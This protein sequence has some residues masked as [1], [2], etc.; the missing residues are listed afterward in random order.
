MPST[1]SSDAS[2]SY[3]SRTTSDETDI[4]VIHSSETGIK[5]DTTVKTIPRAIPS[6]ETYPYTLLQENNNFPVDLEKDG[7]I[8]YFWH[9]HKSGG[10]SMKQA[11]SCLNK[12]QT[13]RIHVPRICSDKEPKLRICN[14][15]NGSRIINADISSVIGIQ[16]AL[17]LELTT[18]GSI[19]GIDKSY[20][21]MGIQEE[22]FIINTSRVYEALRIFNSERKARLFILFRD[23]IER[24]IS[25]YYYMKISTWENT[26]D[27]EVAKMDL[28]TYVKSK[29]CYSNW[30]TRRLVNKMEGDLSNDD[31]ELAK[32]IL[33]RKALVLLL[34]DFQGSIE[35]VRNFFGWENE[36]LTDEQQIC[37]KSL[38]ENPINANGRKQIVEQGS[39][40]WNIIREKNLMDLQLMSFVTN[41]YK[42]QGALFFQTRN[43]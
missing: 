5:P 10:S 11:F 24:V 18:K 19:Y 40:E 42:E 30:V 26:Y 4:V 13:K 2:L 36:I 23:P 21:E 22:P 7:D 9:I 3:S 16:R 31:L 39:L 8:P 1:M 33:K 43:R 37:L 6:I 27:P 35:R 12:I 28:L 32:D 34:D 29:H 15:G 20:T 41:L 14:V 25:K 38:N 17:D